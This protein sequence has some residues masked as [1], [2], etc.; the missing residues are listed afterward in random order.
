MGHHAY[1]GSQNGVVFA[2]QHLG[3]LA[4]KVSA[5]DC[6]FDPDLGFH[7]LAFGIGQLAD[8]RR[9]VAPFSPG[10]SQIRTD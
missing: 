1:D 8:K 5:L 7:R 4:I 6:E 9:F 10:F 2:I 3:S